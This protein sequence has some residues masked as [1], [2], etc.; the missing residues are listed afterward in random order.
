M[1]VSIVKV[2]SRKQLRDF[3]SFPEKLYAD[4]PY[5]VPALRG[6]EFDTFDRKNNGAYEYCDSELYLAYKDG[7]IVGRVAALI[8]F[9]ANR[10]WNQSTVRFGWLDFIEDIEVLQA[11]MDAVAQWGREK[12]CREMKGP[13]G[14]TDMDKEGLLV[15]GFDKLCPFTCI[16]NYPY[17]VTML[18]QLGFTKDVDWTQKIVDIEPQLPEMFKFCDIVEKRSGL[19]M[20]HAKTT[21][22]LADKYGLDIFHLYNEAF[23]PLFQFTPLTDKQ[24]KRYL[25]T[26]RAIMSPD[27]IAICL[28]EKEEPV[29]FGFCVPSLAKAVKKSGGRMFPLGWLRILKAL[30]KN[31]V[32]EALMIGTLPEYQGKGA[33]LLVMRELHQNC[34]KLGIEKM[35]MNP[36][37]EENSKV[38]TLFDGF[39]YEIYM[40]RRSYRKDI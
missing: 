9:N 26:Y 36:Q 5:W 12:G 31:D 2:Q 13:L 24:I 27:F 15:E 16:Y 38:Q 28:N 18:E 7:E 35:I 14:F 11:L 25:Q 3:I 34:V 17:Y 33:T 37:L 39:N 29:G 1:T 19:H 20:A 22:E 21:G 40:R 23:V 6:D 4:N 30:K 10:D 8:N 32:L